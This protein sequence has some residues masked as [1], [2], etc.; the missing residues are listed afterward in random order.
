MNAAAATADADERH[1]KYDQVQ[2]IVSNDAVEFILYWPDNLG[3]WRDNISG[4]VPP[5][6]D[7]IDASQIAKG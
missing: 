7:V 3:A 2:D 5:V 1:V 6:D 4:Y